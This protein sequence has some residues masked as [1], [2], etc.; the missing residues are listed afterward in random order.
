[1]KG[2]SFTKTLVVGV[3]FALITLMVYGSG[4]SLHYK[5][6]PYLVL[7]S[8]FIIFIIEKGL[9]FNNYIIKILS[10][11]SFIIFITSY[12]YFNH[13]VHHTPYLNYF[14]YS[15]SGT[16]IAITSYHIVRDNYRYAKFLVMLTIAFYIVGIF[17]FFRAQEQLELLHANTAYYFILM[18]LPLLLL[19]KKNKALHIVA[20]IVSTILCILSVKRGA[21]IAISVIWILYVL[22][23]V[24]SKN[25]LPYIIIGSIAFI[26]VNRYMPKND[27]MASTE[28]LEERFRGISSDGGSGRTDIIQEFFE[29]DIADTFKIPEIFIGNGFEATLFKY[30]SLSSMHNDFLEVFYCYGVVGFILLVLLY[31]NIIQ[32]TINLIKVKSHLSLAYICLCLLYIFFS[33]IGCNFNYYSLSAPLFIALGTFEALIDSKCVSKI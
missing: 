32:T 7:C 18:P 15:I 21:M 28:R 4:V 13:Y 6:A 3:W 5:V 11:L 12:H 27:I 20:L 19:N 31:K 26:G 25:I 2:L 17:R 29:N 33:F 9:Y 14:C 10:L 16:S 22:F 24:K 8:L 30:K 1:M 23:S